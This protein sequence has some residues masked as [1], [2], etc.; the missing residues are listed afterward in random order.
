MTRIGILGSEG[1]MGRAIAAAI[2]ESDA[3]HAGGVDA[4]GDAMTLAERCDVLVDFTA[5]AALSANLD[6]AE[7]KG[8]AIVIGTTGLSADDHARIDAAAKR[9]AV[10]Q[11][12]NTSLGVVMLCALVE[13]AAAALGKD[14]DVE[15]AEMHHRMK[16]DAPSGTALMLGEAAAKGHGDSLDAVRVSGRDG[17][18]GA[19]ETGTIGFSALRGGTVAGDH[20]VVFAGEGERIELTHRA[21]DRAIFARGAVRAALWLHDRV[22]G[23]YT[24]NQVLGM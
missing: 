10:L 7:A 8:C 3:S 2:A 23:R 17:H 22:P 13:K 14:W 16:V 18:T 20:M 12:G 21:E 19:R 5:P 11:T 1:R 15:I 4:S 6:A 24:M 9:I